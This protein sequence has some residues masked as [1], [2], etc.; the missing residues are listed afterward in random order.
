MTLLPDKN[1]L[2]AVTT[3]HDMINDSRIL[4]AVG[5]AMR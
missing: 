4:E 5:P 2:A 3:R 1:P